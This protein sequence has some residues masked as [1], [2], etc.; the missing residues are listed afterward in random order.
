MISRGPDIL[1]PV[2][3][4]GWYTFHMIQ[5]FHNRPIYILLALLAIGAVAFMA[6]A[7]GRTE[8]VAVVTATVER[9]DVEQLVSVSGVIEAEQTAELAFPVSGIV[10][11]VH[12]TEGD[13]VAAGDVLVSLETRVLNADRADARAALARAVA[14]RDELAAGADPTARA[15]TAETITLKEATLATIKA[16]QADLVANAYRTLLS[17]NLSAVSEDSDEAA[18]AP[19]ITGT[20]SCDEEGTYTLETY[21][22]SG[23]SGFS[24][25]LSGLETGSQSVSFDQAAP[26]GI[27]GLRAQFDRNSSYRNTTWTISIPNTQSSQYVQNRN[28]YA[29]AQTQADSAIA[30][31][32]QDII[33]TRA[34][35]DSSNAPARSEAIA[36]ANADI[37]SANAR[38]AR[39]DAQ[40]ADR[41]IRAPFAGTVTDIDILPGE[42]ASN[43]PVVTI[44]AQ[45]D[46]ELTARIPEIDIGKL[47][48][49][50]TVSAVF[51]ARTTETLTGTIDYISL[52]ATQIDG[53]SY[54]EAIINIDTTP[55]WLRSGLNADIDISTTKAIDVLRVPKR[56]VEEVDGVAQVLLPTAGETSMVKTVDILLEGDDGFVALTGL[57]EGDIVVAP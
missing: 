53:V 15:A 57:T 12:V 55:T 8:S 27:C 34:N 24:Y 6:F 30:L 17:G 42:T 13:V 18:V 7:L 26:L 54:Y 21:S 51:D 3:F 25:R 48:V 50:Q 43:V 35:A 31:A 16:T 32:E 37:M 5:L 52:Q 49:G 36:R 33:L 56:F 11:S 40:L 46:F 28:A 44:L 23:A 47:E 41:V 19:V 39:I 20:Y 2:C 45:A 22:S 1:R 14:T 9:G 10:A 29:L 38:I 4:G